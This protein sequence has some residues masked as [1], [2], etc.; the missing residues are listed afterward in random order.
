M[1]NIEDPAARP[2]ANHADARAD[3]AALPNGA[4]RASPVAHPLRPNS[5]ADLAVDDWDMLFDAVK[6]RIRSTVSEQPLVPNDLSAHDTTTRV[7]ACVLECVAALDQLHTM[8]TQERAR[9]RQLETEVLEVRIALAQTLAELVGTQAGEWQACHLAQHDALTALP[10]RS[11]FFEQLEHELTPIGLVLP[12]LA[13][14]YL[15]L[16]GFKQINDSH[17]HEAGDEVL[18]IVAARLAGAVRA[19]DMVSRLGGDEFACLLVNPPSREQLGR[20]ADKL[21]NSVSAPLI[22]GA[23]Q[24]TVRPSIGIAVCPADGSTIEALLGSADAAMSGAKRQRSGH[25]FVDG[26]TSA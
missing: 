24:V 23:I 16:D 19:E 14:F 15:D 21:F 10:N 20:L 3:K 5:S 4:K 26:R 2:S 8:L 18:K 17:G 9:R 13:L 7:R 1:L 12:T 22:M 6:D 11:F 25:A